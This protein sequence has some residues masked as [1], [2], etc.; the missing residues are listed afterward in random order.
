[1]PFT[2]MKNCCAP[3]FSKEKKSEME[4]SFNYNV[5]PKYKPMTK[6]EI[7]EAFNWSLAEKKQGRV[8]LLPIKS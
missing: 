5:L 6:E 1:M 2:K 4:R 7:I 8:P 3:I